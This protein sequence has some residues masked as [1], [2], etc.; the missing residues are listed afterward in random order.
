MCLCLYREVPVSESVFD[1]FLLSTA[2]CVHN[3]FHGLY[4]EFEPWLRLI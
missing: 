1:R 3:Q 4:A 2:F